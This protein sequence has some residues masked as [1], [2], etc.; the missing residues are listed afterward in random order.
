MPE[1][2]TFVPGPQYDG[3]LT[4][5]DQIGY[6]G[7]YNPEQWSQEVW[8][9]DVR[10]MNEAGVNLVSLGIFSWA[11]LEPR[12][13]EFDFT[14][15]DRVIELLHEGGVRI[16]LATPTAAPPAW[17]FAAHPDA[18]VVDRNGTP[19]G[20]GSRGL[21]APTAPAYRQAA[22]RIT[23]EL[24]Q[25]YGTHPAVVGW[26]VHNEYGA[27]VM[28]D[29]S[30]HAQRAFREWLRERHGSLD[31]LNA[32]WGTAFWGQHYADW[33]H[34]QVPAAAPTSVNPAQQLDFARFS[35]AALRACF[36]AERDAIREHS[37]A[38]VTTN[39]MAGTCPSAD[40]FAW[41]TEVDIVSNDHYLDAADPRGHVGLAMAAD[42]TRSVAGGKP[43]LLLEHSTS[44]VN[45]QPRNVA[46]RPGEL[47]RNSFSHLGRGA[48]SVMFF[49]WRASRSGAEKFHSAMLPHAGTGSRVWREVT[50]LGAHLG[51]LTELRGS[52]VHA[53]VA[54]LWD[55]ESFWAQDLEHRPSEG[56]SHRERVE[57][58]Y[59]RLW[60][61]GHTVDLVLPSQDLSG[62]KLVVAP[63]SY[64]LTSEAA[65]NL[66]A[67]VEAGG[68]LLVSYFSG[69]VDQNDA[70]H[71]G[72]F[73]APLRDALGVWVEEFLP[74]RA[75]DSLGV[76]YRAGAAG[77]G[78]A[79]MEATELTGTVWADDLVLDGAEPVATYIDGPKPGGAAITRHRHGAGTG[80]YVSTNLDVEA[81]APVMADVYAGAGLAPSGTVEGLE[82]V[83]RTADEATYTVAINHTDDDAK[84]P[85]D[86]PA[87]DL[88][89]GDAVA[90]DADVPAGS[91]R[92]LRTTTS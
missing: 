22:L 48:D 84:L 56:A 10:L 41:A 61:D 30:V 69:I 80:W 92:V 28:F 37:A 40:L 7:D 24:A 27:P 11:L 78:T 6:G 63:A 67:Y 23:T 42:L 31:A 1:T 16:L 47:A 34:V 3:W 18:R 60:R 49:Q 8:A 39:F 36:V 4:G 68:T 25:R 71:P 53:D 59:D 9:E 52:R 12:E 33:E 87:T 70:V 15:L 43:W 44:A 62:Y 38:P 88:L 86:A 13:G 89:T 20:P 2:P 21:M 26:H 54:L 51:R 76:A 14:W 85:L 55:Y 73:M 29:Y 35:D 90:G 5:V 75:G 45:W 17:L 64:L 50:E 19:M 66:T 91:V 32:A 74:L 77:A 79:S 57:T 82:V 83:R 65:A 58:Y 81:L 72:G 46:K